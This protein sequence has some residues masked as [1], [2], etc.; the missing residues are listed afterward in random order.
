MNWLYHLNVHDY[1]NMLCVYRFYRRPKLTYVSQNSF[2]VW[3]RWQQHSAVICEQIQVHIFRYWY[4]TISHGINCTVTEVR[5]IIA[6][7]LTCILQAQDILKYLHRVV[8][9]VFLIRIIIYHLVTWYFKSYTLHWYPNPITFLAF[10]FREMFSFFF[11]LQVFCLSCED[12]FL[13]YVVSWRVSASNP[14]N[15]PQLSSKCML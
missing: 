7:G 14:S 4:R 3:D 9:Q 1:Q 15:V 10:S 13:R 2:I 5:T 11:L 8:K 12:F 6:T